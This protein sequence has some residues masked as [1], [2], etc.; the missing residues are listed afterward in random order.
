VIGREDLHIDPDVPQHGY[1]RI[2][3][4][5]A[6]IGL[7]LTRNHCYVQNLHAID[8]RQPSL[9]P[10]VGHDY[11]WHLYETVVGGRLQPTPL[12]CILFVEAEY[13]QRA[14]R[15]SMPPCHAGRW[16]ARPAP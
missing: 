6:V 14:S 1:G 13:A 7:M 15:A 3:P 12:Y 8:H 4:A 16:R 5:R 10:G 2:S 9:L 11:E